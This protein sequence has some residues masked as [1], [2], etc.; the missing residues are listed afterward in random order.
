MNEKKKQR[1]KK[2]GSR[3]KKK[4]KN[5]DN[6]LKI[7]S[8]RLFFL[9]CVL[10]RHLGAQPHTTLAVV[11]CRQHVVSKCLEKNTTLCMCKRE[12][13]RERERQ[14]QRDREREWKLKIV[15]RKMT[16]INRK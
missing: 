1:N 14:R 11:V 16:N 15:E 13:E 8:D 6:V 3:K 12:R 2:T 10:K 7:F 4:K 5:T 9:L